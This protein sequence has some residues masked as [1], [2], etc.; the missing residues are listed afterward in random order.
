MWTTTEAPLLD[1]FAAPKAS[2]KATA[3]KQ[4]ETIKLIDRQFA[5]NLAISME[6]GLKMTMWRVDRSIFSMR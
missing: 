6:T 3:K 5:Q 2:P 4:E 1:E